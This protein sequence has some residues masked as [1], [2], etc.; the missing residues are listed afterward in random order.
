MIIA[1]HCNMKLNRSR[2][3]Q[4]I[5][6]IAVIKFGTSRFNTPNRVAEFSLAGIGHN[7]NH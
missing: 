4:R 2:P 6:L 5:K 1:E 3:K 7:E